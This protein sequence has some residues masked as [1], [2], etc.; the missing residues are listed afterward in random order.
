MKLTFSRPLTFASIGEENGPARTIGGLAVPWNVIANASTGPV[1][2][3]PG[4][5]PTDGPNPKLLR[6][7]D[8]TSPIGLVNKR[9]NTA[10]GM[11]FE[12][13]ISETEDGDDALVLAA[14]GVLDMVSVGVEPTDYSWE[15]GV[16]VV[17]AGVWNELSL[18]PFGAFTEARID[19]VALSGAEASM[20]T[21]E[22]DPNEPNPTTGTADNETTETPEEEIMEEVNASAE[23]ATIPTAPIRIAAAAPRPVSAAKYITEI[24]RDGRPSAQSLAYIE[25]AGEVP[26]DIPGLIPELLVRPVYDALSGYRPFVT[27]LGTY[28]MPGGSETFYRRYVSQHVEVDVQNNPLDTLASQA[29]QV[30]R[31]QVDKK[32]FGGYVSVSEQAQA[33]SDEALLGLILTDLARIY[34]RRTETYAVQT[35]AGAQGATTQ[36]TDWSD[37]DEV[38]E[39]LFLA[40]AQ[41]KGNTFRM[42]THLVVST[43]VWAKLGAAKDS[44]GN[45]VFPFVGPFN[46]SGQIGGVTNINGNPLGLN[47]VVSA[48]LPYEID[49]AGNTTDAVILNNEA[50]ELFEDQRGALSLINP[51][52]LSTTLAFRGMFAAAIIDN[53][54][55][56]RFQH[57]A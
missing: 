22:P 56:L 51:S 24:L 25:A 46:A 11:R 36:I 57:V 42:P 35:L 38:V 10:D 5:L 33:Y 13:R 55:A 49:M 45:R 16:L 50:V 52:N 31:L 4:S 41:I 37:G 12:A 14:D 43:E 23:L 27:A 15:N 29:Y 21:Q 6:D 39:K 17:K 48:D 9:E 8:L 30:E 19:H 54:R 40:A 7:H 2:F 26:S 44:G 1:K 47:L 53:D 34:G 32:W 28:A 18:L 3:L 20:Y